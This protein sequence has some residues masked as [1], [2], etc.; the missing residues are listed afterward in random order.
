MPSST[1]P[2]AQGPLLGPG[3]RTGQTPRWHHPQLSQ[4]TKG[5]ASTSALEADRSEPGS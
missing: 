1:Y 4:P 2:S 5:L 3:E